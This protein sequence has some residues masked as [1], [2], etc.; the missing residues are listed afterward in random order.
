MGIFVIRDLACVQHLCYI[1][2]K[3]LDGQ[4]FA[5]NTGV[6]NTNEKGGML[7]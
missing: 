4:R 7:S 6:A 2:L 1:K 5:T 3:E